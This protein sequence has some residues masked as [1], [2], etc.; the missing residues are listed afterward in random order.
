MRRIMIVDDEK[1]ILDLLETFLAGKGFEIIRSDN[2][3]AALEILDKGGEVD[4][5]ILDHRMPK[6]DGATVVNELKKKEIKKMPVI[7][8]TGSLG[9]VTKSL[10]ADA[11]MMKPV[12]LTVLYNKVKELLNL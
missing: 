3:A 11:F 12:D 9:E 8:L 2:G 5:L 1:G 6:M 7:L 10:G 4:L